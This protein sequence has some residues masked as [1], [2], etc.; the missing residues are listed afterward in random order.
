MSEEDSTVWKYTEIMLHDVARLEKM[1]K[2]IEEYVRFS[3][4]YHFDFVKTDVVPLV[5]RARD[6][7]I[8][9]MPES[10]AKKINFSIEAEKSLPQVDVDIAA[11]EEVFFNLIRNAF[12]AMPNGGRLR[13][14]IKNLRAGILVSFIDNGVGIHREDISDIFNPFFTSKTSGAGMGLTKAHLLLEEHR[15]TVRVSSEPGKGSTFEVFLPVER[16][17]ASIYPWETRRT[18]ASSRSSI[19]K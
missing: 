13:V 12:E 16:S 4:L 7:A 15:G 1:V 5:E 14:V 17:V 8:Q 3:K 11:M 10:F 2:D 9:L 19:K 18:G 6:K